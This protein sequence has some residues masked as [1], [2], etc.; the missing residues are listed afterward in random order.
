[1]PKAEFCLYLYLF[2]CGRIRQTKMNSINHLCIRTHA[3]THTH[4]FIYN[5]LIL[6]RTCS[7]SSNCVRVVFGHSFPRQ[8][9]SKVTYTYI[10]YCTL[11][12]FNELSGLNWLIVTAHQI[13]KLHSTRMLL[14]EIT[15][16]SEVFIPVVQST[17]RADAVGPF[18]PTHRQ[19]S[20]VCSKPRHRDTRCPP[21]RV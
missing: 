10:T 5:N 13:G 3:R 21:V 1:M 19:S 4:L 16:P 8:N 14:R 11:S 12:H 6:F 20:A 9:L 15:Y 7:Q 18:H 2:R 17:L